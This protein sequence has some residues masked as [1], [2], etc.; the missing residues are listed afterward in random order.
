[1]SVLQPVH[2][3]LCVVVSECLFVKSHCTG[4]FI[5]RMES[6]NG[7]ARPA[8]LSGAHPCSPS[9]ISRSGVTTCPNQDI[10][11]FS[12][13]HAADCPHKRWTWD[14]YIWE[15]LRGIRIVKPVKNSPLEMGGGIGQS[16]AVQRISELPVGEP[17]ATPLISRCSRPIAAVQLY[18][19]R[20]M[21]RSETKRPAGQG[22]SAG[23]YNTFWQPA[24]TQARTIPEHWI[25][26]W[27]QVQSC[28][29]AVLLDF[30][31]KKRKRKKPAKCA[32]QAMN[33]DKSVNSW[34]CLNHVI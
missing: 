23:I 21:I 15:G 3:N 1:M 32:V 25:C 22:A 10:C 33:V 9:K 8:S 4:P 26:S 31:K 7:V 34:R 29:L 27:K 24:W 18:Q 19:Q 6:V 11:T 17:H 28:T 5:S 14:G 12:M 20:T 16:W 2:K 30:T 13:V